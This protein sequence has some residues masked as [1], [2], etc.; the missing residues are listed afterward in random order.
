[1]ERCSGYKS[2]RLVP[3]CNIAKQ[4]L[5]NYHNHLI[6]FSTAYQTRVDALEKKFIKKESKKHKGHR[7]KFRSDE[8]PSCYIQKLSKYLKRYK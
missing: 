4:Q 6:G 1:M 2:Y 8:S 3:I 5:N 7:K